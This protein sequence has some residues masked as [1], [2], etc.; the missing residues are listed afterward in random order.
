M[1]EKHH[2]ASMP[3]PVKTFAEVDTV[4]PTE[5]LY[6]LLGALATYFDQ[7]AVNR[8]GW[9]QFGDDGQMVG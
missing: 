3:V 4:M 7:D 8:A 9:Q 6:L 2:P 1:A 5:P